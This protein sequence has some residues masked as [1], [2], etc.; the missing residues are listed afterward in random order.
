[1]TST[2]S[3]TSLP[4]PPGKFGFPMIGE[5]ISFLR[6]P[7]FADKRQK[8]YGSIFKTHLFGRPTVIMMGAEA[9]RF[10]FA[11]ENKYFIVAWPLS[12]RIL[13][14]QGSL[15]MQLGDIHKS[16]R[17]I[18]SQAFQPR[19][20]A[21]YATTMED[22]TH[23]YLHKWEQKSTLI[24]YPELRKY[25]FD[26]ACK[27]LIGKQQATDTNL[28]VLFEDWC[29]GLFTIPLRLPGTKFN[30]GWQCRQ[31]LLTE[32]ETLIR[33]RQQQPQSGEDAL[34]LL[35][36]AQDEDGN[37]LGIEELKDQIL[38]LLFAGHETLTSAIASFCLE[39][40]QRP[41][42]IAKI[43]AEQQQFDPTQPI[44][45]EDLKSMTYL[46]QVMKEVLRFVPPVGGG[47]R[48]VIQDCEYNGYFIP[49]DWSILYQ[50][51]KTHQD[52]TVYFQP[53]EFDPERFSETRNED[54]PKPFSWV[55]F[56]GGMRECIGKE[57]AKLEIKLF[58]ALLVRNY[59]WQLLPNQSLDL[60]TI[61]TPRP[62]DGLKVQLRRLND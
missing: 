23:R 27:L 21:G 24:W 5:T 40:G 17:K 46:E 19:A 35:L 31:L 13:L 22:F 28:E 8:Q 6:D 56:G 43:R 37:Q 32:I 26:I 10:L 47:F 48:E 29:N 38:T 39:V 55:P 57:F 25:T 42:I 61:P 50:I 16:R 15:S 45:F 18:L 53:Q 54:K 3:I 2:Q 49:K 41:D 59:D 20:L 33:Q 4:L 62:R 51:A 30:R 12:T 9:N 60:I 11:N 1:M 14:G 52:E 44:T 58:A 34:G 7:D 36:Q